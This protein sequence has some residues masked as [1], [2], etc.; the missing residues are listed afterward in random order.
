MK[1]QVLILVP[2]FLL[3]VLMAN[4]RLHERPAQYYPDWY[5][6][7]YVLNRALRET[8]IREMSLI[9]G[10]SYTYTSINPEYF[11]GGGDSYY[12]FARG[13]TSSFDTLQWLRR[14]GIYPKELLVELNAAQSGARYFGKFDM[15]VT[16][17]EGAW[18]QVRAFIEIKL[19]YFSEKFLGFTTYMVVPDDVIKTWRE[20]RSLWAI[21]R[22]VF[23]INW[24]NV[25]DLGHANYRFHENGHQEDMNLYTP[26]QITE[27]T[28]E[29]VAG[30]D[31]AMAALAPYSGS[32]AV[33][34]QDFVRDFA[35]HGT[36]L[37]FFRLPKHP[38]VIL[39]E[40]RHVSGMFDAARE[41]AQANP[42]VRYIDLSGHDDL[43]KFVPFLSDGGH[44]TSQ[45]AVLIS[46]ELAR[47]LMDS[48][49]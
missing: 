48:G 21:F 15:I 36:K 44:W 3:L 41:L 45:G 17:I 37:I 12:N 27:R 16:P 5:R 20:T 11:E 4:K 43:E 28:R 9:V 19:R 47:R 38:E 32:D 26:E 31:E 2:F 42:A 30:C 24:D 14:V 49:R 22:F 1:K 6:L 8:G 10:N 39:S 40:N 23:W 7:S 18:G 34:L 35:A 25:R 13:G 33:A 46:K 29:A